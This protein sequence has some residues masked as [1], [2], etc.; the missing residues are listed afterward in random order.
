MKIILMCLHILFLGASPAFAA[1]SLPPAGYP[2]ALADAATPHLAVTPPPG[3]PV[4]DYISPDAVPLTD[5][6]KLALRLSGDWSRQN[7]DPVLTPGGKILYVHGAALPTIVAVPYQVCDVELEPG[8]LVNEIVVGDSSRWLVDTGTAGTGAKATAHIF[9][10]PIDAGLQTSA[11]VTTDRRV[12]HLRFVSQREG[13]TPYVGF[14]YSDMIRQRQSLQQS[15]EAREREW[16]TAAIDGV[17]RDLSSLNFAY[18]VRGKARW[19]PEQVYDDGRQIFIRLPASASSGEMPVLLVRK[20]GND[21][22][23]NYRARGKTLIVD[24]VFD[25]LV[26]ILGVGSD[27]EKVEIVKGD[28][29]MRIPLVALLLAVSLASG[30]AHKGLTGSYYGDLPRNGAPALIAADA[31]SCLSD[32]YPPGR[33]TLRLLAAEKA[34]NAFAAALENGLRAKGFTLLPE[35]AAEQED[36]VLVAYTLDVLEKDA[37]YYLQLRLS[38]GKSGGKAISKAYTAQG[39]PEAGRSA[40]EQAFTRPLLERMEQKARRVYDSAADAASGVLE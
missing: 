24:G 22:L 27:Q 20:S 15:R 4:I 30:C 9:V 1:S 8:E 21:V 19:K 32:L 35:T 16:N 39:T 40:T 3:N 6:E 18:E 26:L 23:V 2:P 13:H 12:Y 37:A 33:T 10:K 17:T 7:I 34:D 5:T 29:M 14:A 31:V 11:V 28:K 36:A 25:R 38:D